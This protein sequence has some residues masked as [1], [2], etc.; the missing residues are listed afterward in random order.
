MKLPRYCSRQENYPDGFPGS[1]WAPTSTPFLLAGFIVD[2]QTSINVIGFS[3]DRFKVFDTDA[4]LARA[5][6][7]HEMWIVDASKIHWMKPIVTRH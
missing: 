5:V 4:Y 3:P 7:H 2:G 1:I 6:K